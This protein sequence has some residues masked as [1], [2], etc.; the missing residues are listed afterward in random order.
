[1]I[2]LWKLE[3]G[4]IFGIDHVQARGVLPYMMS[5]AMEDDKYNMF[6]RHNV[7]MSSRNSPKEGLALDLGRSEWVIDSSAEHS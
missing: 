2:M 7:V 6:S 5:M 3:V 4:S 1:M